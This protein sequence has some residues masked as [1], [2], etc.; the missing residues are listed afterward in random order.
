MTALG[1]GGQDEAALGAVPDAF[2]AP[3]AKRL[4]TALAAL[5]SQGSAF[6]LRLQR[7]DGGRVLAV[8]GARARATKAWE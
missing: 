2:E 7:K 1:L 3:D 4:S 6:E 8:R 5:R